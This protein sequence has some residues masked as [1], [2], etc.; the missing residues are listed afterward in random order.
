MFNQRMKRLKTHLLA[1]PCFA[2]AALGGCTTDAQEASISTIGQSLSVSMS[3]DSQYMAKKLTTKTGE[4]STIGI[5]LADPAQ[6]RFVMNR[7]AAA[8]KNVENSPYL[9]ERI[10]ANK[11]KA[12]QRASLAG[13]AA[14][15]VVQP[16][17]WCANLILLGSEKRVSSTIKF[18]ATRPNVSCSGGAAYVYVDVTTYNANRSGTEN[19]LVESAAGE[20]YTGG[21][22]FT[23]VAITPVLPAQLGRINKTDSLLIAYDDL[24]NEQ[25]TFSAVTSGIL[26]LPGSIQLQHPTLHPQVSN[27][28]VVQMC[29]LRGTD[30]ECDY[31]VGNRVGAAFASF[32]T[33]V[34]GIA[35]VGSV[36][37]W[38]PDPSAMF[39][40][41][42]AFNSSHVYLPT[43]GVL[44]VGQSDAGNCAI[45]SI[46]SAKFNL[47]KTITGG[48]CV[49]ASSFASSIITTI[50]PRKATFSTVSDFTN[51]GGTGSPATTDCSLSKIVNE[52]VKPSIVVTA[53]VNCGELNPDGSPLL[54]PRTITLT[55][56]GGSP[57][58][59]FVKFLNSC[60]AE[61]TTIRRAG[62]STVAVEKLAVGDKV[63]S[64]AKGTVLTVTGVS[65]GIE[66]EPLVDIRDS[67]DHQLRLT[68][69]H[70][71]VKASG[72]VVFASSIQT[73]DEVMTDRGVASIVSVARVPYAGKV[74]NLKLG[75]K[76]ELAKVGKNG[77]TMFAG[78][79]LVGDSAMQQ[80]FSTPKSPVAQLSTPWQRDYQNAVAGKPAMARVLR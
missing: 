53:N 8:G 64:D 41:P 2:A 3:A 13:G 19:I 79:F 21:T 43:V 63:I 11:A 68:S 12:M 62:G 32:G 73:G 57:T 1:L 22:N 38:T 40:L 80:E 44:D 61:G 50:A 66:E 26:P 47:V 49:T 33:P 48:A 72:Q 30:N 10:S 75:N 56:D 7:L 29:Q 35:G 14:T 34:N 60:F 76:A 31:R 18:E 15:N 23:A 74:Y 78:G 70:P 27:G 71:V 54:F 28:G 25:M 51:N 42:T 65:N 59:F 36:G 37:P 55:P 16:T 20:D 52:Q 69:K 45:K 5:D 17:G 58:P 67:K 4:S 24:G 39:T 6:Y 77:T 46:A 9:F